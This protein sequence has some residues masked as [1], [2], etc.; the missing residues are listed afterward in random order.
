MSCHAVNP[1]L[2]LVSAL[3]SETCWTRRLSAHGLVLGLDLEFER[4][5]VSDARSTIGVVN[6]VLLEYFFSEIF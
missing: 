4:V 5:Q 6:S 1:F 3:G 2:Q